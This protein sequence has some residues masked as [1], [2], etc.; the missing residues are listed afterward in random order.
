MVNNKSESTIPLITPDKGKFQIAL[1]LI[2]E[3]K[4]CVKGT[5]LKRLNEKLQMSTITKKLIEK[6]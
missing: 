6:Y 1:F 2:Y 3:E 4:T 5:H